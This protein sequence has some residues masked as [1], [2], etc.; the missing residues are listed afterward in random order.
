[1]HVAALV[2][3]V[4]EAET[5]RAAVEQAHKAIDVEA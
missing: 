3:S 4:H 5:S 2:H 1:M